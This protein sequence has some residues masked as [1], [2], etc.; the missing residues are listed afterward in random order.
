MWKIRVKTCLETAMNECLKEAGTASDP[1][2][3]I[4]SELDEMVHKTRLID[5]AKRIKEVLA[6]VDTLP[7]SPKKKK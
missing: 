4:R 3:T 6:E 5:I 2:L 7:S 1:D